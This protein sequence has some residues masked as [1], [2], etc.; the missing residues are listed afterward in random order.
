MM[1]TINRDYY[2]ILGVDREATPEELK[3]A[4]RKLSKQYHPDIN[5]AEDAPIK[6]KEI[7]EAYVILSDPEQ[8][9]KYDRGGFNGSN[10]AFDF[11]GFDFD[12]LLRDLFQG[13]MPVSG[14]DLEYTL[15]LT[16]EELQSG[17]ECIIKYKREKPCVI[18][19]GEGCLQCEKGI[20]TE[21]KAIKIN[22]PVN[23][24]E[25]TSLRVKGMGD[26]GLNG[27]LDGDLYIEIILA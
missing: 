19:N 20:V 8:K 27:G 25:G 17:K 13:N 12:E 6:F 11:K 18:C 7:N 26:K 16:K 4:Y 21:D 3:K 15:T 23:S 14:A 5:K 10:P 2:E 24:H 9:A 1:S 22:V